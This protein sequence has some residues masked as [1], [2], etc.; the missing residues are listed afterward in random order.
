MTPRVLATHRGNRTA[1]IDDHT[2]AGVLAKAERGFAK[3]LPALSACFPGVL[4]SLGAIHI[5]TTKPAAGA[6][7]KFAAD[8]S[9]DADVLRMRSVP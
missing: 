5:F 2:I 9:D 7:G 1:D 3:L 8:N 6:A 4:W